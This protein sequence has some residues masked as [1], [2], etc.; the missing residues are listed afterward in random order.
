[1][2]H[3]GYPN[4]GGSLV[5]D[6]W[7]LTAAHCTARGMSSGKEDIK[8][9]MHDWTTERGDDC[10]QRRTVKRVI[11]H[12]QYNSGTLEHDISLLE[13]DEPV[14]YPPILLGGKEL[15]KKDTPLAVAGWGTTSEGGGGPDRPLKVTVPV[16]E[17]DKC[18]AMI[19]GVLDGMMCAGEQKGGKDSCQG[20]SGGP[21][22]SEADGGRLVGVVSWGYGC[23]RPGQPGVYTRVSEYKDWICDVTQSQELCDRRRHLLAAD[24]TNDVLDTWSTD[25]TAGTDTGTGTGTGEG[26]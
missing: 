1:M 24:D 2:F 18:N 7:V 22:F 11:D 15:E 5:G 6:K 20:D 3:W 23:A 13:L 14:D 17:N 10:V 26:A 8:L 21:L 12:P 4:C 25:A 19:G 9:G 16:I